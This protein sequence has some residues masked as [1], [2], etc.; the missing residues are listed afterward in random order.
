M[1][2]SFLKGNEIS[3]KSPECL[4]MVEK[5]LE[6][7]RAARPFAKNLTKWQ[8][9]PGYDKLHKFD[10]TFRIRKIENYTNYISIQHMIF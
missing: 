7:A 2:N 6:F 5:I 3:A 9:C 8:P 1:R 4:T 10:E